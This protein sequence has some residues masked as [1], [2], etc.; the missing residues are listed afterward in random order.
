MLAWSGQEKAA[1]DSFAQI[2][3]QPLTAS[4]GHCMDAVA[5]AVAAV[6]LSVL[7]KPRHLVVFAQYIVY[8]H[9]QGTVRLLSISQSSSNA[10]TVLRLSLEG[11]ERHASQDPH[12]LVR[13]GSSISSPREA[14]PCLICPDSETSLLLSASGISN[15]PSSAP[16]FFSQRLN[17]GPRQQQQCPCFST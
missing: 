8:H 5:V 9:Y 16:F 17:R 10:T 13:E 12:D 14:L 11:S 4:C 7:S 3:Y 15:L 6:C 2:L 1:L